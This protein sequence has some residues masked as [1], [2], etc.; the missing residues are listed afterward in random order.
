MKIL[1]TSDWHIGHKL[2]GNDRSDEHRLFFDWLLSTIRQQKI[3]VLL[4]CGDIFDIAYPSNQ[5]LKTYYDLL[6]KLVKTDLRKLIIIGGNHDSVT[7]LE[8]PR[9]ILE[10]LNVKVLGGVPDNIEDEIIEI[11]NDAGQTEVVIAA[12]P[13]LRDRDV[14]TPQAGESAPERITAIRQGIV[15]HYHELA[16]LVESYKTQNI[17]VIASGHLFMQ[18][19][20]LSESERDIHIG[21]QAG[22]GADSFPAIFDYFALGH[23]HRAQSISHQ[24]PIIYSGSPIA[25]SYS[26]RNHE[27][28]VRLIHIEE[29]GLKHEKL[30]IPQAR[31]LQSFEGT[32]AQLIEKVD[33]YS[34]DSQLPDWIELNIREENYDPL[35]ARRISDFVEE[36]NARES[37][38]EIIRHTLIFADQSSAG[39]ILPE[40]GKALADMSETEVFERLLEQQNVSDRD[41]LLDTYR[42][43]SEL[44]Y[45]DESEGQ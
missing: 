19:A 30:T 43:L 7:T 6:K 9:E 10:I 40:A 38:F 35:L 15:N 33:A 23:I 12:T 36:S 14:R 32:F 17:P 27:K 25:L 28:S 26:E 24:P 45:S 4:V 1:H 5:S 39:F 44:V 22:V 34:A 41:A 29:S 18:G 42:E 3:D 16:K 20:Q 21:N 11:N 13:F 37:G 8:A 2:Y 31:R